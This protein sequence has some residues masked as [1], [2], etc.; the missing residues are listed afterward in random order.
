MESLNMKKNIIFSLMVILGCIFLVACGS[1]NTATQESVMAEENV[2]E[3]VE[4]TEEL[5]VE[6]A[7]TEETVVE[8]KFV[9]VEFIGEGYDA[10]INASENCVIVGKLDENAEEESYLY[11]AMDANGQLL[12][13]NWY[14]TYKTDLFNN[15]FALGNTN[16]DD[17][18]EWT[19][20]DKNGMFRYGYADINFVG[21]S[22]G[23]VQCDMAGVRA[24]CSDDNTSLQYN[25]YGGEIPGLTA[26]SSVK[27]K[28]IY[29]YCKEFI[30]GHTY[31]TAELMADGSI[32]FEMC[33]IEYFA[34][35]PYVSS[36]QGWVLGVMVD[37]NT[38]GTS[39]AAYN[40]ETLEIKK[41]PEST[42]SMH[43]FNDN[44]GYAYAI[45][46]NNLSAVSLGEFDGKFAIYDLVN[47]QLLTECKYLSFESIEFK[48]NRY[49]V[50]QK[51]DGTWTFLDESYTEVG[52]AYRGIRGFN[53]GYAMVEV[54]EGT[55]YILDENLE[56]VSDAIE[57][58]GV[59]PLM[60]MPKSFAVKRDGSFYLM[61]IK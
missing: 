23:V 15:G 16:S 19:I 35:W 3:V 28:K 50:A 21:Y 26:M 11:N 13:D 2:V 27:D 10:I 9:E 60:N 58:E 12:F 46:Q 61:R 49:I 40:E 48:D 7:T 47:E 59:F 55:A 30:E 31:G 42:M 45:T 36:E 32:N 51:D 57:E 17:K 44:R 41:Y 56:I 18:V 53:N 43:Q 39:W 54:E 5:S 6:E 29:L 34:V 4:T 14:D 24:M 8:N 33:P 1:D 52:E 22:D 25:L 38:M 37:P 20:Y